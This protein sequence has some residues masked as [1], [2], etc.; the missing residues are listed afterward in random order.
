MTPRVALR[1][2]TIALF[3]IGAGAAAPASL[4][5]QDLACDRGEQEVRDL[6]FRGNRAVSDGDLAL[7][8]TTTPSSW[9]RRRLGLPISERRCLD[10]DELPRDL[11][12]LKLYYRERGFYG[13]QVDTLV[14]QLSPSA[15]RVVFL[16]EEGSPTLLRSYEV[17]GLEEI[18]RSAQILSGQRLRVGR[19]FDISLLTADIDS[20]V[21]RLRNSGYYRAT[22]LHE[23]EA[24]HDS[25]LA[26]VSLTV[27]PGKRARFGSPVFVVTPVDDRGQQLSDPVVRR[28]MRISAGDV[29]SDRAITE[30]QRSLFQL[31]TYRHVE[32]APLPD[33]LQ[34]PGD[35]IIVLQVRLT[36]DYMKRMDAEFGW[37]TLDCGRV[38]LQYTDL[39]VLGSARRLELTGHASKIGYGKPLQT[40]H[41]REMCTIGGHSPLRADSI[42]SDT[43]HY[44]TG[45]ALR[46]PRLLGTRWVPTMSL[47]SERRGEYLAYLRAT[48]VGADLS[49]TREMGNRMPLRVAYNL[50]Y[51]R[52]DAPDAVLCALFNR[53][54]QDSRRGVTEEATLGV[55]SV[56][57]ARL[58]TD[59]PVNP[60]RGYFTR[61]EVRT[62]ASAILGTSPNLFFN[63]ASADAGLYVPLGSGNVLAMRLRAGTVVGR[64]LSFTEALPFVPPQER[65]YAGGAASVRG[66]QQNELGDLVY[67]TSD[68]TVVRLDSTSTGSDY[69]YRYEMEPGANFQRFVP[70]GG[71][72]LIVT[73]IDYRLPNPFFLRERMQ[74]T[75]FVDGGN[76]WNRRGRP[77]T[78]KWTPGLGA[79]VVTPVGPIQ[80]NAGYNPYPRVPGL[81]FFNPGAQGSNSPLLY[82]ASP[83]NGVVLTRNTDNVLVP[84][85][86]TPCTGEY[87]PP[88]RRKWYQQLTFTFSIGPDF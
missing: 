22:V 55:A 70:L 51:G 31:G 85:G 60:R 74:F 10:R 15:V 75:L 30:A 4:W 79:R 11:V 43:L 84:V 24:K 54:D 29:Y 25:L 52:T 77:S 32:V 72:S 57:F 42:F 61:A 82:C 6:E 66:F 62:S 63:K 18:P 78:I 69:T 28:V 9:A 68:P 35:T 53:C 37:A 5:S 1:A 21:Q 39:N 26:R 20:I 23:Y 16:I 58:R 86:S 8:V 67:I 33:S 2:A 87:T 34:P 3:A 56:A 88:E 47:Y 64:R 71:N 80:V 45:M 17:T 13:A 46:Q 38:R 76:V 73:N 7:R 41:T 44:F 36:E 27:L 19:P 40:E 50:E 59:N 65:L 48:Y 14:Q 12:Q 83:G 49:A 81:I